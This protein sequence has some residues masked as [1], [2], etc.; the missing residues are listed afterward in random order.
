MIRLQC[1]QCAVIVKVSD[2]TVSRHPV[3][4]C[5]NCQGLVPVRQ[6]IIREPAQPAPAKRRPLKLRRSNS[7]QVPLVV[8]IVAGLLVLCGGGFALY[9]FNRAPSAG[10]IA[11][12]KSENIDNLSLDALYQRL[13]TV[14]EAIVQTL[15]SV[16]TRR[17]A[18]RL[19]TTV[20]DL[21]AEMHRVNAAISNHESKL[22]EE[23]REKNRSSHMPKMLAMLRRLS[24]I[25]LRHRNNPE[26]AQF[27]ADMAASR[28][29]RLDRD[30]SPTS[31]NSPSKPYR[32]VADEAAQDT[33]H[34]T[35]CIQKLST[36]IARLENVTQPSQLSG[37][38][39]DVEA[40]HRELEQIRTQ[41]SDNTLQ[42]LWAASANKKFYNESIGQLSA[43]L[44][45][46]YQRWQRIPGF[47]QALVQ[48]ADRIKRL[49]LDDKLFGFFA[50]DLLNP[51][52]L[53]D[54]DLPDAKS[55]PQNKTRGNA[56]QP[57]T[58]KPPRSISAAEFIEHLRKMR[59]HEKSDTFKSFTMQP[60]RDA[61]RD[62]ALVVLAFFMEDSDFHE[63]EE[64]FKLF[65]KWAGTQTQK[66]KVG[67]H[68]EELLKHHGTRRDAIRWFGENKV[69]S[70]GKEV[71]RVL[72]DRDDDERND[73]AMSLIA[74]GP[75]AEPIVIPY[76]DNLEPRTRHLAI[77]ILAR[78]G[79]RECMPA[80]RKLLKDANNGLAAKQALIIID[81]RHPEK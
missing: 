44:D 15:G 9:W 62:Y 34:L 70:A 6:C 59:P 35:Q 37:L 48:H 55:P 43:R 46:V 25:Q 76:L 23:E 40:Y 18:E 24:A 30:A 26:L 28:Y 22:T 66:E 74:M 56:R 68:A 73:A 12:M 69:I 53:P 54:L 45:A 8:G 14:N 78:I 19:E 21:F 39:E 63:K 60:V 38:I 20:N 65:K 57:E 36:L 1:P 81:K 47:R 49:S 4:R 51:E 58:D 79:T 7:S 42:F 75:Q 2:D 77:E 3:V 33:P 32:S 31:S 50:V 41:T 71:A 29:A 10:Q 5:A 27:F 80:L 13:D 61:D 16:N 67:L 72:R 17:D 64:V 11:A 52:N